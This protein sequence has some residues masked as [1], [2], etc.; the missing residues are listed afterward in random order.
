METNPE[1][2]LGRTVK[3]IETGEELLARA[4][5]ISRSLDRRLKKLL[6]KNNPRKTQHKRSETEK[7]KPT[8]RPNS[9]E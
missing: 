8:T 9:P 6:G 4:R 2:E 7:P 1:S 5:K 3:T